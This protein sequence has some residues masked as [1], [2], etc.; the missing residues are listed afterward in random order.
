MIEVP[1]LLH[2]RVLIIRDFNLHH[3]NW[4]N[5]TVNLT[6]QAKRFA[7]WIANKN[8]RYELEVGTVTHARGGAPDLVIASNS[9]SGQVTECYLEPNLHVTSDHET[10]LTCLK[11]GNPDPKKPSQCR[12]QLDKI[13]EK[14]FF[15]NLEAQKDLIQSALNQAEFSTLGDRHKAL[16]K[17]AKIITTAIFSSLELSTQKS[18]LS[19]KGEPWWDEECRTSLQKM[20]QT[21][22]YQTFDR[23]AG[24]VDLNASAVLKNIR[25]NLR[26]TV[27]K[28][29]Q[30]YYRKVIDGLDHQNIFQA[31]K[32]SSTV[33]AYTTPP[34]QRQDGSLAVDSQEKQKTLREELFSPLTNT[35]Q[36]N[37]EVPNL[38]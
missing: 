19:R 29:K 11:M 7:D 31:V 38:Q 6:L 30:K 33:R 17:S 28:A 14:Q 36:E 26:K 9:V 27:K 16:D 34:I 37:V 5:H 13:D 23:V 8:A 15:S 12:F 4:D 22:K 35:G 21:Q 18:S 24:I 3:T 20:C 25:S 1:E 10:I 2:K 32:W